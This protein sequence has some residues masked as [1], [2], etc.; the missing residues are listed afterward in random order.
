MATEDFVN[1]RLHTVSGIEYKLVN[2]YPRGDE[3]LDSCDWEEEYIIQA[4]DV[5]AFLDESI[6]RRNV[7]GIVGAAVVA[8][9]IGNP[10][11]M[12]GRPELS[13][14][15]VHVEPVDMS[16]PMDPFGADTLTSKT[17]ETYGTLARV[18]IWYSA[19]SRDFFRDVVLSAGAE[20]MQ[21]PPSNLNVSTD[22]N[23]GPLDPSN[24][25]GQSQ[26]ALGTAANHDNLLAAYKLLPTIEWTY[27]LQPFASP[28]WATCFALLGHVNDRKSTL[29][30][31]GATEETVMYSAVSGTRI[32]SN[33]RI[34]NADGSRPNSWL[35]DLKFSQRCIIEGDMT[36]GW[37][38]VYSS[39]T[40]AGKGGW[41]R[42]ERAPKGS[43]KF[44]YEKAD[45]AT[46]LLTATVI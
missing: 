25:T 34:V 20:Y 10:R 22:A 40:N 2:G 8:P 36:Y 23:G 21:V 45:L 37:N 17:T 3:S 24:E 5:D 46:A 19:I 6:S 44:L 31:E 29:L 26:A 33:Y 12:P 43:G 30:C 14:V 9:F 28:D 35:L 41:T 18:H 15:K 7:G 1:V 38:H 11:T 32:Y 16:K 27:K 42:L 39:K 4:K 13:T